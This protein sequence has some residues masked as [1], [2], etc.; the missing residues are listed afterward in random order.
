M[1]GEKGITE[2]HKSGP[3]SGL[4]ERGCEFEGKLT[5]EGTVRI[6]GKFTGEIFSEGTLIIGEGAVVDGKIEVGNIMI[7]GEANGSIKATDRI[8]MHAPAVVQSDITAQTLVIDE[9]VVFEGSCSMGKKGV[10]RSVE[11]EKKAAS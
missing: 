6:N 11:E 5:F 3:I 4:L 7:H 8:E 2:S 1:F 10:L 9:G